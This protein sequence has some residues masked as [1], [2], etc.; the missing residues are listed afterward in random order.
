MN[1]PEIAEIALK[2][3]YVGPQIILEGQDIF[4]RDAEVE[5]LYY[6]LSADR[7]VLLYSPSGAGKSSLIR[8][9]L[10]PRL[11][12]RFEVWGP[13][14]VNEE[15]LVD[16]PAGTNRYR[17]TCKRQ[18][19]STAPQ[20]DLGPAVTLHEFVQRHRK[21]C[22]IALGMENPEIGA[23]SDENIVLIFDQ[24]EEVLNTD[25][26]DLEAKV[27]FFRELGELLQSDR[28]VWALFAIREDYLAQMDPYREYLP[29]QL[30]SRFRLDLLAN[31]QAREAIASLAATGVP[32]RRFSAD[33]IK[34]LTTDLS[35]IQIQQPGG[36]F[37]PKPGNYIEPLYL[38]VVCQ[39]LWNRLDPDT[40]DIELEDVVSLGNVSDALAIY[41]A[42]AVRAIAL[43]AAKRHAR[44][45]GVREET[46]ASTP[47]NPQYTEEV[48]SEAIRNERGIRRWFGKELITSINT[49][50]QVMLEESSSRGLD[51][52]LIEK[53]VK[54]HLVRPEQ[55]ASATWFELSHDRLI[56]PVQSDNNLWFKNNLVRLQE[57]AALWEQ[58]KLDNLLFLGAD[59]KN[60][61]KWAVQNPKLMTPAELEFLRA[62]TRKN[63]AKQ[64]K[65]ALLSCALIATLV[66]VLGVIDAR[67][68]ASKEHAAL[69]E[70]S[71]AL[72][73]SSVLNAQ[74]AL[75]LAGPM[76]E[77]VALAHLAQAVRYDPTSPGARVWISGLLAR[78]PWWMPRTSFVQKDTTCSDLSQDGSM[79]ATG[80][81]DGS[82]QLW[83]AD[84]GQPLA[85]PLI[86]QGEVSH[87]LFDED[88][89]QIMVG[90]GPYLQIWDVRTFQKRGSRIE[91]GSDINHVNFNWDGT[92]ALTTSDADK[93]VRIWDTRTGLM[94]GKPLKHQESVT[95]AQFSTSGHW[96]L[97]AS[98]DGV[99]RIWDADRSLLLR[100]TTAS[101]DDYGKPSWLRHASFSQDDLFV[102]T[103]SNLE[104]RV[105]EIPRNHH[106]DMLLKSTL[107]HG[108]SIRFA[109][110]SPIDHNIVVT[111]SLDNTA[112]IRHWTDCDEKGDSKNEACK[113]SEMTLKH[114]ASLWGAWFSEDGKR[115]ATESYDDSIQVWDAQSG[116][117]VGGP[118]PNT[119]E[120]NGLGISRDGKRMLISAEGGGAHLWEL[121]EPL[122]GKG[123]VVTDKINIVY[124]RDTQAGPRGV[125]VDDADN[126]RL[127]DNLETPVLK[128]ISFQ[129]WQTV[130]LAE[131]GHHAL[132]SRLQ[133]VPDSVNPSGNLAPG[134]QVWDFSTGQPIGPI[135]PSSDSA[136][137]SDDGSRVLLQNSKTVTVYDAVTGKALGSF[138]NQDIAPRIRSHQG[139]SIFSHD[140]SKVVTAYL[141][142]AQIWNAQTGALI[143]KE[144]TRDLSINDAE[145][146]R[147]G[148]WLVVASNDATASLWD[149]STGELVGKPLRHGG[150]VD[151]VEFSPD[152]QEKY[153]LT[154]TKNG[155][156]QV[157][158]AKTRKKMGAP[159][160][161]G[162][163]TL[164]MY[165]SPDGTM[166]VSRT[167]NAAQVWEASSGEKLGEP[168][169]QEKP[170]RVALF[171]SDGSRVVTF[172]KEDRKVRSYRI[173]LGSGSAE[174]NTL[175]SQM[176]EIAGA[177]QIDDVT[178]APKV[179]HPTNRIKRMEELRKQYKIDAKEPFLQAFIKKLSEPAK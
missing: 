54:E 120:L 145:F 151:S 150:I 137:I 107:K 116:L 43:E 90:S 123:E 29:A 136:T 103:T 23:P 34:K 6:Q 152:P 166:I 7:I 129:P 18:F 2:N 95:S 26:L 24:F 92:R 167:P 146:S 35:I 47:E 110:F 113:A 63:Y 57:I 130:K 3:P 46:Y 77:S 17:R 168:I 89:S 84:T 165:F 67:H 10:M 97:T 179:Y 86:G 65:T 162:M 125:G 102:V 100:S 58:D 94:V 73:Q 33:A 74:G 11:K 153:F 156:G 115:I 174:D 158:D 75:L 99:A 127:L 72:A 147:D 87:C 177:Y 126:Y 27:V 53:L 142:N 109:E 38:Q 119:S 155:L 68:E 79:V 118:I 69:K 81:K 32:Q 19:D 39:N 48:E 175:L 172:S 112:K 51:N 14:R 169:T 4:G 37:E 5:D 164:G 83:N 50:A 66:A 163:D 178:R 28:H 64:A 160:H 45:I 85:P 55:R 176:A 82:V 122:S 88:G 42:Q 36:K 20:E 12:E 13:V 15:M 132:L 59:L 61:F 41:Y 22:R 8:A 30:K 78:K 31:K 157:W 60:A 104:V 121:E 44:Q 124:G 111:A 117:P 52:L 93:S 16:A 71:V 56:S 148:K 1:P 143:G 170:I 140:G 131:D 49:R 133:D 161:L 9:G 154:Q 149:A 101:L 141:W 40:T 25:P 96:V 108:D 173:T 171:T 144:M 128:P 134:A 80:S 70:A 21:R 135:L 106:G 62:S 138:T 114:E 98:A 91:L 105:W 139:S 159:I 76:G